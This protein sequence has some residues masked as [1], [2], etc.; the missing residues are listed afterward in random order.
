MTL[1]FSRMTS[2]MGIK[3]RN[4]PPLQGTTVAR[5]PQ[6]VASALPPTITPRTIWKSCHNSNRKLLDYFNYPN[7]MTEC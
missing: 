7:G 5:L 1:I 3:I 2:N 6:A 4:M